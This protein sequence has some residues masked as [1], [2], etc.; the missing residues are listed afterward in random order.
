MNEERKEWLVNNCEG[1][2]LE[3]SPT[4][5]AGFKNHEATLAPHFGGFWSA[6]WDTVE[7]VLAGDRNFTAGDVR[8]QSWTWL[9]YGDEVPRTLQQYIR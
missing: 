1:C 6:S 5:V 8:L 2:T 3:G 7:R 4:T 9:G